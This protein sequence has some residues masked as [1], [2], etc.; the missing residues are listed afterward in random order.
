MAYYKLE[1]FGQERDNWHT[2]LLAAM[3]ANRHREKGKPVMQPS[4]F[5]WGAEDNSKKRQTTSTLAALDALA[6][7]NGPDKT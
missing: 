1:P 6:V 2:G 5:L 4:D 7:K 3:Y